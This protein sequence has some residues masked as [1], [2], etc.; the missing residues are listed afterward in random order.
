ML[1][2]HLQRQS[3]RGPVKTRDLDLKDRSMILTM[4]LLQDAT[5]G[6]VVVTTEETMM[7]GM[8]G[9]M[10]DIGIKYSK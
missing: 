2:L 8:V 9:H 5:V 3:L 7:V 4:I 10:G 6:N 1:G